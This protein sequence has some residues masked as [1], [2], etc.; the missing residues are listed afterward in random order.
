M[1]SYLLDDEAEEE[2]HNVLD[3]HYWNL[4]AEKMNG[5]GPY[6]QKDSARKA[7]KIR[8]FYNNLHKAILQREK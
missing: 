5:S 4:V 2:L 8:K 3:S 7:E 1:G 6:T